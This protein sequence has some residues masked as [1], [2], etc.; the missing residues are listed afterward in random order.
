[1]GMQPITTLPTRATV[2]DY[3][4]A[5]RRIP[6]WLQRTDLLLIQ[7][8]HELQKK[9]GVKGDLLEI[10]VLHGRSAILLGYLLG[11]NE[12]LVV[13]DLFADDGKKRRLPAPSR[14]TFE[15]NYLQFHGNLPRVLECSSLELAAHCDGNSFRLIHIDGGHS[16][17]VARADLRTAKTLLVDGGFVVVDDYLN[18]KFPGVA[19]AV[20]EAV[21]TADLVPICLSE[22]KMYATWSSDPTKQLASLPRLD[23]W[24]RGEGLQSEVHSLLGRDV[25]KVRPRPRPTALAKASR[26]VEVIAFHPSALIHRLGRTNRPAAIMARRA[27]LTRVAAL[28]SSFMARW[29][30][31]AAPMKWANEHSRRPL[32]TL[33]KRRP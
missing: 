7:A 27:G 17:D 32:A 31:R 8:V 25:L 16:Y 29:I 15:R 12:S 11:E 5:Y 28:G 21:A 10:G 4:S 14:A 2:N 20:W 33:S 24:A 30:G 3:L 6:G 23:A 26:R 19:A 18:R 13:C 9:Q 22:A 1:V